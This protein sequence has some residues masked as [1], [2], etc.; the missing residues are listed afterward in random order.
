MGILGISRCTEH[1]TA[2]SFQQN[3]FLG[4]VEIK[5]KVTW[6][7]SRDKHLWRGLCA[8]GKTGF[9]TKQKLLRSV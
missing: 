5:F 3:T 1:K 7:G 4:L 6:W 8:E 9:I 2:Q